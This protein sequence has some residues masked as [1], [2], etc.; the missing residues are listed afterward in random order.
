MTFYLGEKENLFQ[1][2]ESSI[3]WS[4]KTK[5]PKDTSR[6]H[7][8]RSKPD[9]RGYMSKALCLNS[10]PRKFSESRTVCHTK[11]PSFTMTTNALQ[12]DADSSMK[13]TGSKHK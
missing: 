11:A 9:L 3:S 8:D 7:H 1:N 13:Y 2:N 12:E 4:S 5:D 10:D 6:Q